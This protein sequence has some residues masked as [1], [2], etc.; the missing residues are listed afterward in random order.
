M[1]SRV[2]QTRLT[3]PYPTVDSQLV[4][5]SIFMSKAHEEKMESGCT[6]HKHNVDASGDLHLNKYFEDK[7]SVLIERLACELKRFLDGSKA[8]EPMSYHIVEIW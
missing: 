2:N 1:V 8:F 5:P 7:I 6:V 4:F 3:T